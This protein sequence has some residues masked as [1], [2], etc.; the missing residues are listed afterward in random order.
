MKNKKGMTI[1]ADEFAH[2]SR[3]EQN[4]F[5]RRCI[6]D[7]VADR[8]EENAISIS[9]IM[10]YQGLYRLGVSNQRITQLARGLL[11]RRKVLRFACGL[12]YC[13]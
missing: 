6:V 1:T 4:A 10:Y 11:I 8:T 3:V 13:P 2:M 9:L 12:Y 7:E 5:L